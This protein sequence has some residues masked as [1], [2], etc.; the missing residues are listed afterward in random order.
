ME[1][2]L[3]A[4]PP[5]LSGGEQ[6][7]VAV[8]RAVA[9][10]PK[11]ILADEPTGSLDSEAAGFVFELLKGFHTRGVTVVIATHDKDLI[12]R[13]GGRVVQ[14]AAGRLVESHDI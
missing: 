11:I 14:L 10:D 9:G 2:R 5:S 7:R 3:T 6:Q 13:S 1:D 4:F 12:R 8:A